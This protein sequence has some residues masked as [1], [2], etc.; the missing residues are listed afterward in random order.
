MVNKETYEETLAHVHT[1]S[2]PSELRITDIR[3]TDIVGGPFHSS[4]IKVYTNQG[5]VGFGE[6]RDGADKVYALML[7]SRLL[8]ENPCNIDKLFRRIKQFGGHARQGGGV[9]GLE[10]A[11]WDLA[12]KAYGVPIYQMLGGKFRDRVR[13]YCDTDVVGKD[14]GK[15]MGEALKKRMEAGFTFL[16]MDLGI[17]QL[18]NEPGTLSAPL[19]FLEDMRE[20]SKRRY[21]RDKGDLTEQE[22][23]EIKNR[24]YD[25]FNIPHPF[26]GIHI[27]EKGLDMLEQYVAEVRSVIGNHVPLA[28][29]HFGHIGLE[30]CIKL[31][32]RIDKFNLAWME[33][34]IPWQYTDQYARLSHAVT[35]PICTGEDIYLKENFKP[36]L[37]AGG[38]SVIHPDVLTAGGILETKK[39]G[40]MAQD[41]GVAMAIHMAE[42]PIACLAAAHVAV[43]TEN[44]LAL[45]YHSCDVDWWDDIVI[46]SRLPERIVQNGFITLTDAPG[47]GIDDLNDEVLAAHLHPEI[48][49]LWESTDQWN[50]H[51]SNDR[52]WS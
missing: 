48:G 25:I 1:S 49:G 18:I 21:A 14:T 47:L 10:I 6:V 36:L 4:L 8:G 19:G 39:I 27:T 17:G 13:M 46:G 42:S 11:L 52:Q 24:H 26:T 12:G 38:V 45:E 20:I 30:D 5:L 28:I 9:S 15:A 29:D 44:F 3:F 2:S 16:K 50:Y 51:Y 23:R 41:Y 31:G 32:R 35:T 34:M 33:D 40:D 43:A 37:E 7:K 22:L